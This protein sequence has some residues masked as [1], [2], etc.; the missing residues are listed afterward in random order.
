MEQLYEIIDAMKNEII[1]TLINMVKIKAISPESGGEGEFDRAEFLMSVLEK[2]G[3][4]EIKRFDAPDERAKN[5]VR[6][7]IIAIL[8]GK[9]KTKTLWFVTHMDT[10][11]EGDIK[12]WNSDPFDPIIKGDRIIGRGVED[13]G[14]SLIAS[15]FAVKALKK[16][17][18]TPNMNIGLALVADEEVGSK[19]GIQYLLEQNVFKEDDLFLV[20]DAG[21]EDGSFIEVAE[22]SLLW[23]K[24]TIMGKQAHASMP[25]VGINAH[26]WGMRFILELDD[27]LHKKFNK[28]DDLFSPPESTFEIT[29][30]EPNDVSI[31]IIPGK[32]IVYIDARILPDYKIDDILSVINDLAKQY[33][34]MIMKECKEKFSDATK[35]DE[36][37]LGIKPEVVYRVDAPPPTSTD[38]EIVVKL[39]EAIKRVMKIEPKVGGIGGGTCAAFFRENKMPAAVW[40]TVLETAHQPNEYILIKNLINDTKVF[41]TLATL[42]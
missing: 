20:P 30:K 2:I 41:A 39:K 21:K 10:V 37:D 5:G 35:C 11:P 13:N 36:K 16:A 23:L 34:E 8:H 3:F 32:D 9:D 26:R 1:D 18:I 28:K 15:I 19:Y 7:N 24:F 27:K 14:Q 42:V 25:N 40:S 22:K 31:N 29:K 12:K 17:K 6:P 4:D 33:N 38:S